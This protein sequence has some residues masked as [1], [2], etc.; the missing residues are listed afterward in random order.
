MKIID[1]AADQSLLCIDYDF[2]ED[3]PLHRELSRRQFQPGISEKEWWRYHNIHLG[4][5]TLVAYDGSRPIGHIEFMPID[6]APFPVVGENLMMIH[7]MLVA[8]HARGSGVGWGLL[9][10]AE[11]EARATSDGVAVFTGRS[12]SFM[13]A[14]FFAHCGYLAADRS[15][16]DWLL[17]KPFRDI[18][19]PE[20]LP[21]R[22]RSRGKDDR[23]NVA[24]FHCPQCPMS[25]WALER[26]RSQLKDHQDKIDLQVVHL[27][28]RSKI[29]HYGLAR[30][31]FIGRQQ[32][33][34]FPPNPDLV[35]QQIARASQKRDL[36]A[37]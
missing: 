27:D 5:R 26:I 13:P 33:G 21:M 35:L 6:Q 8:K 9:E 14:S 22:P 3:Y 16:K 11:E 15:N 37:A 20:L 24:F 2:E 17:Y 1:E 10:A 32:V 30:G 28:D 29:E 18:A 7:C 4:L 23:L 25:G 19:P 31:L 36:A 34:R 12:K